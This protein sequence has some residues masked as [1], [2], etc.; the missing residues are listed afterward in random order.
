MGADQGKKEFDMALANFVHDFASGG[1]IRHLADQGYTVTQ[2][3]ER[4][5]FPT[6]KERVAQTVWKH[7]VNTGK[8]SLEE[9]DAG[10]HE[11]VTFVQ[12]YGEFGKP[13]LRRV[14]EKVELP[15]R[16]FFC[17]DFGIRK[18]KDRAGF[19]KVLEVLSEEDR[20]YILDLPWPVGK[21]YHEADERMTRIM[22]GLKFT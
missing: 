16:S 7:F 6:P 8:I 13:F 20:Q 4:L 9:P 2:I 5:D 18:Y 15:D 22:N 11:K 3:K 12:E 1:A 17:C 21:V 19:E 10:I 14:T